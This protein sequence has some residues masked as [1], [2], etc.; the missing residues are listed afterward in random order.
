MSKNGNITS[1]FKRASKDSQSSGAPS[2]PSQSLTA[3]PPSQPDSQSP[4]KVPFSSSSRPR[5]SR[6]PSSPPPFLSSPAAPSL[7]PQPR[8]RDAVIQG[9]D[10]EDEDD[11]FISSDDDLPPL[12]SKPTT[13]TAMPI[14]PARKDAN[15]CVTPRA[16]RTAIAFHSSPLSIRKPK[17]KFDMKALL[18]HA[19]AENAIEESEQRVASVMSRPSEPVAAPKKAPGSLHDNMLNVL[20]DDDGSQNEGRREK[21][22]RAVKRTGEDAERKEYPFFDKDHSR[23]ADDFSIGARPLFPRATAT[24]VWK[25]LAP[26]KSRVEFFEDGLPYNI[27]A[28][29]QSLPDE[30]FL[31]VLHETP[32]EKSRKLREE[33]LRLLGVC[34][35][36][37]SE[38][39][40]EETIVQLFR[41]L[42]ASG[43]ALDF[44][45]QA[46]KT[47]SEYERWEPYK[48]RDWTPLR[49]VLRILAET[50]H[51]LELQSLIRS[52]AILLRLGMDNLMR[53]DH[54]IQTDH[55]DAMLR[56]VQAVPKVSWDH[57]CGAVCTSLYDHVEEACLR[58]DAVS[59]IPITDPRLIELRR[60]LS[61]VCVFDAPQRASARPEDH[62]S[63]RAVVDQL[64][65]D[66]FVVDRHNTD[67]YELAA[68]TDLLSVVIGDG[69]PPLGGGPEAIKQYNAEVD[70]VARRLKI[71]YS[72]IHEQGG[73]FASRL[74]AK[75]KLKDLERKLHHATRT[76]P[77]PKESVFGL[78]TSE[79]DA[80]RP[81]QQR[82]MQRFLAKGARG[83]PKTP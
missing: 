38:Y 17:H 27:Q 60:R 65:A 48:Q 19:E 37:A 81:R 77:P 6:L 78:R 14:P 16:K 51:G 83:R 59:S 25:F 72:N 67:Y 29:M 61:I 74:D 69:N 62:F 52:V 39:I 45:L 49:S 76:R 26:A 42:G 56:L 11:D 70:E 20:S 58:W 40:S 57:F 47:S 4:P 54:L 55:Q 35:D 21:V 5:T 80:A 18:K 32:F 53:E 10:D 24:G 30:I 68:L 8:P 79:D 71:L 9:S 36:H 34:P 2:Q 63:M 31:W 13:S 28:K 22:L 7:K 82:F 15:P 66:K 43:R 75:T 41:N 23:S 44:A 1:F 3:P 33:Y 64:E 46:S 12:F 50:A 73:A